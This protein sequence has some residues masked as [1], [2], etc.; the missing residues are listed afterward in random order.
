MATPWLPAKI[1]TTGARWLV[2]ASTA[3]PPADE[4]I[5]W[6]DVETSLRRPAVVLGQWNAST[7]TMEPVELVGMWDATLGRVVPLG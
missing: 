3:P 5:G 1:S 2:D 6:W 7:K 4:P